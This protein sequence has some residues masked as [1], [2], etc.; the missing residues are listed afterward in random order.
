MLY[1]FRFSWLPRRPRSR[2]IRVPPVHTHKEDVVHINSPFLPYTAKNM[3]LLPCSSYFLLR[4][5]RAGQ[6]AVRWWSSAA[7]RRQHHQQVV[8]SLRLYRIL[9]RRLASSFPNDDKILLQ[10]PLRASEWGHA[11]RLELP[12]PPQAAHQDDDDEEDDAVMLRLFRFVAGWCNG[13]GGDHQNDNDSS[14]NPFIETWLKEVSKDVACD[15]DDDDDDDN[16]NKSLQ[17]S[18]WVTRRQA[19]KALRR[20]FRTSSAE[21][22]AT[23]K[24]WQG[25]AIQVAS[26]LHEQLAMRQRTSVSVDEA[27]GVRVVATS[28]YE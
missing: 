5:R 4:T 12:P 7:P 17:E 18:L 3:L 10:R 22:A 13:G 14:S 28:R 23:I 21:A 24:N 26:M 2:F 6:G 27:H 25:V 16:N 8:V 1:F 9:L 11:Q 20:A 19:Q 15:K